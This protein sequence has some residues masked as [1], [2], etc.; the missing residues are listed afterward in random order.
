[1]SAFKKIQSLPVATR[2]EGAIVGKIDDF[3][4]DLESGRIFGFRLTKGVFSKA[5]GIS[6]DAL[7]LFGRDLV[8]VR[9]E[10]AVAWTGAARVAVEGR[11][12]A[13][14]YRGTKVMSR[15]G[16]GLGAVEDF[17]VATGPARVTALLLDGNRVALYD[18][19]VA[20]G[21]DAV[22]LADAERALT[23]PEADEEG[24][25]LW[26]RMR[27]LFESEKK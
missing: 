6:A 5:G 3:Q 1:M 21:R 13:S 8:F 15:R 7:E 19:Q 10:E 23:R 25:E 2:V 24:G 11:A 18:D 12:W 4:F 9:D 22:I 17:V 16:E 14:E 27:G 26:K 20:V